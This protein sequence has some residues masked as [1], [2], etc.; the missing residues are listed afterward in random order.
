[1]KPRKAVMEIDDHGNNYLTK[2]Y[3]RDLCA[4][5]GLYEIPKLV[6]T[7]YLNFKGIKMIQCLDEYINLKVLYLNDNLISKIENLEKLK[8]LKML[9]LQHNVI[10]KIEKLSVLENLTIL[11][12]SSNKITVIENIATLTKLSTLNV[13][14]NLIYSIADIQELKLC[15]SIQTL[16][17]DLNQFEDPNGFVDFFGELKNIITLNLNG[18][19]VLKNIDSSRKEII[20]VMP[21]L[22]FYNDLPVTELERKKSE[23][24]S[25]GGYREEN[26]VKEKYFEEQKQKKAIEKEKNKKY[27]DWQ[28]SMQKKHLAMIAEKEKKENIGPNEEED[29]KENINIKDAEKEI[30]SEVIAKT[31]SVQSNQNINL[32]KDYNHPD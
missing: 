27:D 21:H 8:Q 14:N 5:L 19:P 17:L 9:Y 24:Y 2:K 23:A 29:K 28:R 7:L 30:L 6:E 25:S 12:L 31:E 20:G 11:D 3:I 15:P 13:S 1:M 32:S 18:N 10:E 26:K 16:N 4:E 22:S